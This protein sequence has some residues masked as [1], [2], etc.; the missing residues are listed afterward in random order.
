MASELI[1]DE[2]VAPSSLRG[3]LAD[4]FRFYSTKDIPQP[5][6]KHPVYPV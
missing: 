1:I 5:P 3:V 4:R 6:R 2:I